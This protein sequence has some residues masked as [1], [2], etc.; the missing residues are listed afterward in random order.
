MKLKYLVLFVMFFISSVL[1][2]EVI[3]I[4][5]EVLLEGNGKVLGIVIVIEIFYGLL[6]ILN[7]I[8]LVVGIY[9]FYLYEN[10]SC[11]LG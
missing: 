5:N 7:L 3:V 8:G 4:M 6:F 11:I 9:G 2:V 1:V 10:L